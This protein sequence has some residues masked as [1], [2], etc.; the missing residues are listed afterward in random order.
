MREEDLKAYQGLEKQRAFLLRSPRFGLV[1]VSTQLPNLTVT[2]PIQIPVST[3]EYNYR[4]KFIPTYYQGPNT[5][6]QQIEYCVD[7]SITTDPSG[8]IIFWRR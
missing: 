8:I 3:S 1:V 5:R 2:L 6:K 4:Y 7:H